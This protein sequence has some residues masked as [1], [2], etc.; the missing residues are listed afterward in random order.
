M[1]MMMI[2][3]MLMMMV[4]TV[5]PA[6][7][8]WEEGLHDRT[9]QVST[10]RAP[11]HFTS[12]HGAIII[13]RHHN[14]LHL[15][16]MSSSRGNSRAFR[17][18]TWALRLNISLLWSRSFSYLVDCNSTLLN[19]VKGERKSGGGRDSRKE[20]GV[21]NLFVSYW[22]T[23]VFVK[24]SPLEFVICGGHLPP[25]ISL[26]ETVWPLKKQISM[27]HNFKKVKVP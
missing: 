26:S 13:I 25:P 11:T 2:M 14:Q 10:K 15:R 21:S 1:M 9:W 18:Q 22:V 5:A 19:S 3:V 6:A 8:I 16:A 7:A 4:M 23:T 17:I 24:G 20:C 27:N 12:F